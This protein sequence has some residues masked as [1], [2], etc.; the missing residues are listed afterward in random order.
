MRLPSHEIGFDLADS[1][2]H[3]RYRDNARRFPERRNISANSV[4]VPRF[5]N[6]KISTP[7]PAQL[8]I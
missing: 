4:G 6:M 5:S 7:Q 1:L 3:A 2:N 8:L